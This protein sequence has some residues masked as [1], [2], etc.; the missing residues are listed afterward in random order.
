MGSRFRGNDE[1]AG[2]ATP[3]AIAEFAP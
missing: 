3:V 2:A 1:V